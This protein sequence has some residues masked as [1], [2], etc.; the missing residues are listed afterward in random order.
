MGEDRA[1]M[2]VY[3]SGAAFWLAAELEWRRRGQ[4]ALDT[5]LQAFAQ[6]C[7]DPPRAW[8]P[9]DFIARLDQLGG[10]DVLAT[11]FGPWRTRTDFPPTDA[12]YAALGLRR[13]GEALRVEP[14]AAARRLRDAIMHPRAH[15]SR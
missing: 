9:R 7:L 2:R 4:P 12:L 10:G 5:R 8:M 1:Y 15:P 11:M 13:D 6:C 3:W 14:G